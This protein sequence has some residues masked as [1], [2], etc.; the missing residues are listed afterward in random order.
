MST[1]SPLS[2]QPDHIAA[3]LAERGLGWVQRVDCFDSIESTNDYLLQSRDSVHGHLCVTDFQSRGK[4]RRGKQWQAAPGSSLMFSLGW[5]PEGPL[6]AEISLVVGVA[7]AD[8]LRAMGVSG[9][10]LKWPNDLLA[11]GRKLA[12]VLVESRTLEQRSEVVIGVGLNLHHHQAEMRQ[13][14]R[15][16]TDLSRLGFKAL[17]R[18]SL[19]V[20]ILARLGQR[21]QQ[22][23]RTGFAAARADWLDYHAF[24]DCEISFRHREQRR[25]GTV[26]GVDEQGAL[27]IRTDGR[28]VPVYSGEVSL[29]Q[30]LA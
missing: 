30:E 29:L 25:V 19:L 11:D 21:L 5:Q 6:R 9:L 27:L 16:W 10:G 3:Q 18:Q 15:S 14:E 22:F 4:G 20:D 24:Q 28:V 23:E 13:V 7:L 17:D 2:L 8:A 1:L 26:V 12:G